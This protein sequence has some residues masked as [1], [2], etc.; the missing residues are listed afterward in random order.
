MT[1]LKFLFWT[2]LKTKTSNE[3]GK[4]SIPERQLAG[5]V[6]PGSPGCIYL[7]QPWLSRQG[8]LWAVVGK[9]SPLPPTACP[10]LGTELAQRVLQPDRA[11]Q[12]PGLLLLGR[13]PCASSFLSEEEEARLKKTWPDPS[14][15]SHGVQFPCYRNKPSASV[16]KR[17]QEGSGMF[18]GSHSWATKMAHSHRNSPQPPPA[19]FWGARL[20]GG[21][22]GHP[23]RASA[24]SMVRLMVLFTCSFFH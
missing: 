19:G 11:P 12:L 7:L 2:N 13:A 15:G 17:D 8:F 3:E 5:F 4:K 18:C 20:A 22:P 10:A 23:V 9:H 24:G 6:C 14:L 1:A 21:V 16:L